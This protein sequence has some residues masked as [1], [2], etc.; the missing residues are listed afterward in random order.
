MKYRI[1]T[2][3]LKILR[4]IKSHKK[5]KRLHIKIMISLSLQIGLQ[6]GREISTILLTIVVDG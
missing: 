6:G 4:D 2:N 3:L 5:S 1:K